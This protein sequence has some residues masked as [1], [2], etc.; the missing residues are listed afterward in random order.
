[1]I[2]K[3]R[4]IIS[5]VLLVFIYLLL[6]PSQTIADNRDMVFESIA[7]SEERQARSLEKI[8]YELEQLRKNNKY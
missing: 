2:T 3:E 6:N 4:I 1:M 8:A 7:R 5:G